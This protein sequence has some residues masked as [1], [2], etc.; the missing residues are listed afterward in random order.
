[1]NHFEAVQSEA[2]GTHGIFTYKT[3]HAMGVQSPELAR[4]IKNGRIVKVGHGV[5]RITTYPMQA[6]VTEMACLLA[7]VG[8]GSYLYGETALGFL[9]LCPTRS[10]VVFV[11]TP[12]RCRRT[13]AEGIRV[14]R[15]KPGYKPMYENGI[16]CQRVLDAIL[17]SVGT[18]DSSRL[19]EA[20]EEAVAKGYL[21]EAEALALKEKLEDGSA[22][23]E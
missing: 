14:I 11:A 2:M 18:V 7:E 4:W 16:P 9:D 20:T 13:L 5:Y 10:Y 8:D 23:Q 21:S 22:T 17:S 6:A 12:N 1:M 3:A 15:G 19:V